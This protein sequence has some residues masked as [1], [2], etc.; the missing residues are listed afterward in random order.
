MNA[1]TLSSGVSENVNDNEKDAPLFEN[2][3]GVLAVP[4]VH[5]SKNAWVAR[6]GGVV[7]EGEV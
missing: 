2:G 6:I 4:V 7:Y 5:P 1:E 3:R